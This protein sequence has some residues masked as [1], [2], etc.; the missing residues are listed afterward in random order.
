MNQGEEMEEKKKGWLFYPI[1]S[2]A[3]CFR[4]KEREE[5]WGIGEK[6]RRSREEGEEEEEEEEEEKKKEKRGKRERS[7]RWQQLGLQHLC[8]LQVEIEE[9]MCGAS[10][11]RREE[12][13]KKKKRGGRGWL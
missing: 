8:F 12:D 9:R 13:E 4:V 2:H 10:G 7:E 5:L 6:K 11:R 1:A 3:L